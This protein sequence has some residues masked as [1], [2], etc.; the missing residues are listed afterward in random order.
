MKNDLCIPLY[1]LSYL[2]NV[3]EYSGLSEEELD[4]FKASY[5]KD[6]LISIIDA[7]SWGKEHPECDFTTLYSIPKKYTNEQVY[8]YICVLDESLSKLRME[9]N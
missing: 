3:S 6:K 8:N 1:A 7:I 4:A 9:I 2:T 5:S